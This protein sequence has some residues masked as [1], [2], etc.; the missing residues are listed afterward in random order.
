M[1]EGF[2]AELWDGGIRP[3]SWATGKFKRRSVLGFGIKPE[4]KVIGYT[5]KKCG[6]TELYT[7]PRK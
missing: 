7:K 5:C 2:L 1:E 4:K 6:Y 3:V